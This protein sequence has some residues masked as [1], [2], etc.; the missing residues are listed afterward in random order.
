MGVDEILHA[1]HLQLLEEVDS[2]PLHL[3]RMLLLRILHTLIHLRK[4]LDCP[5]QLP[6]TSVTTAASLRSDALL[7]TAR[8]RRD[9][10]QR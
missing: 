6:E 1:L 8:E 5:S 2:L 3:Q 9:G 10:A 7:V 4:S